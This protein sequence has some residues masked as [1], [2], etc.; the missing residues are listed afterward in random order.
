MKNLVVA[1][2]ARVSSDQQTQA[3]TIASQV[4]ALRARV[5]ADGCVLLP[6]VSLLMKDIVARR[7]SV[8]AWNAYATSVPMAESSGCTCIR[9]IA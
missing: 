5:T 6:S 9:R 3:Q 8:R 7:W 2:Y 4:A 1:I